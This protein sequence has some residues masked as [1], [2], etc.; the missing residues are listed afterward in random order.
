M[1]FFIAGPNAATLLHTKAQTAR[2]SVTT[3]VLP[4]FLFPLMSTLTYFPPISF[5]KRKSGIVFGHH[6]SACMCL[7]IDV[8]CYWTNDQFWRNKFGTYF[9]AVHPKATFFSLSVIN[10]N[11]HV[12]TVHPLPCLLQEYKI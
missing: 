5:H 4:F 3:A 9:S 11:K 10:N 1:L 8:S 7:R 6:Q 12:R 2:H